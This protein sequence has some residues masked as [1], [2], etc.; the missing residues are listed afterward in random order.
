MNKGFF[1]QVLL[2]LLPLLK[3]QLLSNVWSIFGLMTRI[4]ITRNYHFT[5]STLHILKYFSV[6]CDESGGL[7]MYLSKVVRDVFKWYSY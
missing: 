6:S 3:P 7:V 4:P 1:S 2:L 5:K